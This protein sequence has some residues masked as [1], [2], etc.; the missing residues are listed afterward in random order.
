MDADAAGGKAAARIAADLAGIA[1]EVRVLDLD[2]EREDGFD[3]SDFVLELRANSGTVEG[4]RA[5]LVDCA[6]RAPLFELPPEPAA[7]APPSEA[8]DLAEL[9]DAVAGFVRAFV[10][11]GDAELAAVALW[12][13]HTHA[14]EASD[15]TP[16]VVDGPCE[17][18][19]ARAQ[20]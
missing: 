15:A 19:R 2:P 6:E 4:I 8:V 18:G 13:A 16:Y 7:A 17:C 11:L 9:L 12:T 14:I 3:L 5:L 1:A 20:G 10:V